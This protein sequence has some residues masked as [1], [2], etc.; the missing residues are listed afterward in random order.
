VQ[1][2]QPRTTL[3]D[4]LANR[5]TFQGPAYMLE[6]QSLGEMALDD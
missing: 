2:N 5:D 1:N 3:R 6:Q 4:G